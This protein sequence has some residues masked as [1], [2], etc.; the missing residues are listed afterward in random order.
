MTAPLTDIEAVYAL[1][2]GDMEAVNRCITDRLHSEV[3]LVNQLSGYIVDSGGKRLRPLLVLLSARA[4]GFDGDRHIELAAIIEFI[5]TATLLHDDVVDGSLLRRG[6]NTANQVWGSEA[7]VLVGDFLYSR[8]F[9]MM[10]SLQDMRVMDIL[11]HATNIIAEGEVMQLLN[12]HD[13]DTS[14]ERYRRVIYC[15]TAKL[16]EA[17]SQLGAVAADRSQADIDALSAYGRHLGNA[18]QLVDDVLDYGASDTDIGK[19]IGDDLA[20]GNPTLP[21]IHVLQHGTP[22]QVELVRNA[23]EHGGKENMAEIINTVE[24]SGA[25]AYTA[26]AARDEAR[27]AQDALPEHLDPA[28][29]K[30]LLGLAEFAVSRT[31]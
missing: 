5:H 28:Y 8:S 18:Y 24:T 13:A 15:K 3:E 20:E 12:R 29:R 1:A 21:L 11:S 31:F 9:E 22:E 6:K 7:S 30:A 4:C 2:A 17:A 27:K 16:F 19:N 10:V 14:E 25:I 26:A 23:I